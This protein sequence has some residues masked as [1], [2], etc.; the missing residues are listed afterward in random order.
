MRSL[1]GDLLPAAIRPQSVVV[2]D[3]ARAETPV[4]YTHDQIQTPF[5]P[6]FGLEQQMAAF[7]EEPTLFSVVSRLATAVSQTEW[8]L[9]R[10]VANGERVEVTSHAALDLWEAPNAF[11]TLQAFTETFD[12]HLELTGES[13]WVIQSASG[14]PLG[15]PLSLWPIRP[16]R[17]APVPDADNFL[18]GWIY[19][20][21]DGERVPLEVSEVVALRYPNPLD[22]YRGL[23]PVA[24]LSVDLDASIQASQWSRNF[25]RNSAQPGGLL[26]VPELLTDDEFNLLRGRWNEQHKGVAAAHRVAIIEAGLKWVDRSFSMKD[27]QFAELRKASDEQIMLAFGMSKILLGQSESVNRATAEAAEYVFGKYQLRPRLVRIRGAVNTC[28]LPRYPRGETLEFDFED[29]VTGN[30]EEEATERDSKIAA[31]TALVD[32][33]ADPEATAEAL[34]LPPTDYGSADPRALAE[35]IQKVYLGVEGNTVIRVDEARQLINDAGGTLTG[36]APAPKPAAGLGI[37]ASHHPPHHHHHQ[38]RPRG[39]EPDLDPAD[40]PDTSRLDA[41]HNDIFDRLFALWAG[42]EARQKADLIAQIRAIAA[43]GTLAD[44]DTLTADIDEATEALTEAMTEAA[45]AGAEALEA[46]AAEQGVSIDPATVDPGLIAGAAAVTAGL[47]GQRLVDSAKGAAMRAQAPTATVD[48][49]VEAVETSLDALSEEGPRPRLTGALVGSENEGRLETMRA[50]PV[51][52]AY[53]DEVLDA[54]TCPPCRAIDGKWLG[55]I[56]DDIDQIRELYPG[57]GFGGYVDCDGRERCRGTVVAVF[58]PTR[59]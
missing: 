31:W 59:A 38:W 43:D 57:A 20:A 47:I 42:I 18:S 52:A 49:V 56:P 48:Q 39:Q 35:L 41:A 36:P 34:G 9:Y 33:G 23:S 6:K 15:L 55:T 11:M 29:P 4:P 17:M 44:L 7:G 2:L 51:G 16:D 45:E 14:D 25:F 26:E 27:L 19:T 21:P 46:E 54:N 8:R 13:M 24:A 50:G 32:N 22:I 53:A 58:R 5:T 12:Q 3:P 28:L 30:V 10:R 37:Q 1:V 40:L